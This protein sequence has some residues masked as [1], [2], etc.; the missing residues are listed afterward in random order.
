MQRCSH[1]I[2]DVGLPSAFA[3]AHRQLFAFAKLPD[4]P[5]RAIETVNAATTVSTVT[6]CKTSSYWCQGVK[7]RSGEASTLLEGEWKR[8]VCRAPQDGEVNVQTLPFGTAISLPAGLVLQIDPSRLWGKRGRSEPAADTLDRLGNWPSRAFASRLAADRHDL[9]TLKTLV[10]HEHAGDPFDIERFSKAN[11]ST[12][13]HLFSELLDKHI[14][15]LSFRENWSMQR[16]IAGVTDEALLE[17]AV[18]RPRLTEHAIGRLAELRHQQRAS[19]ALDSELEA[20]LSQEP[21]Y[22][23][24]ISSGGLVPLLS[25]F[26]EEAATAVLRKLILE[27]NGDSQRAAIAEQLLLSTLAATGASVFG[28]RREDAATTLAAVVKAVASTEP[29]D[30]KESLRVLVAITLTRAADAGIDVS[31]VV[32]V[33]DVRQETQPS[34]ATPVLEV[35]RVLTTRVQHGTELSESRRGRV[36]LLKSADPSK[37]ELREVLSDPDWL[38]QRTALE[39]LDDDDA[40]SNAL[41]KPDSQVFMAEK[42]PRHVLSSMTTSTISP[43]GLCE[44]ALARG[45]L[46]ADDALHHQ[47][48]SLRLKAIK[49]ASQASLCALIRHERNY[50]VRSAAVARVTDSEALEQLKAWL[51][52]QLMRSSHEFELINSRQRNLLLQQLASEHAMAGDVTTARGAI[53]SID[54]ELVLWELNQ[55]PELALWAGRRLQSLQEWY[56][57]F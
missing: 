41:Q 42:A 20:L 55:I 51:S 19:A 25:S 26:D 13:Q 7:I 40:W 8:I 50:E 48:P 9:E 5:V 2:G 32:D 21:P 24:H 31:E 36:R 46:A 4:E 28:H 44:V 35:W 23:L 34:A 12:A 49:H 6:R 47:V 37:D 30:V 39:L 33:S 14:D 10:T 29:S 57:P 54:D 1:Q 52:S 45:V 53:Q 11:P 38:L 56:E 16:L 43:T 18:Q 17:R 15:A 22:E 27:S 3:A